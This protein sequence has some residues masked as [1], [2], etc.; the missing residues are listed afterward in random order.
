M[1]PLWIILS[2]VGLIFLALKQ[3][4]FAKSLTLLK[5]VPVT[6]REH[7][8][9]VSLIIPACN[10]ATMIGSAL[11]S[12][13][14]MNY[15][16]LEIIAVNDRSTDDTGEILARLAAKS[17]KVKAITVSKLPEGWLGKVHA[18]HL[19]L[20]SAT[21][22]WILFTDADV[23][24]QKE[25]LK[26][27]LAHCL[28]KNIDFLTL[29]PQIHARSLGLK[30]CMTQFLM[31][32]SLGIDIPRMREAKFPDAVGC[33]AFNLVR[34]KAYGATRGLEWLKMEVV[35]DGSFA[36]MMKSSGASCDVLSGLGEIDLEWYP[37]VRGY[38][39]GLEKNAFSIFQYLP[40]AVV[41][42][43]LLVV[44]WLFGLVVAPVLYISW[45]THIVLL[46]AFVFYQ[47][48][49]YKVLKKISEFPPY[50]LLF[51]PMSLLLSI[52]VIWRSMVLFLVR[53]G[54]YWRKTFYSQ[55][56]LI[57]NQRLKLIDLFFF[58]KKRE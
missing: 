29:V 50:V 27:A 41:L 7:W 55:E 8:P 37:N 26:K 32:G 42:F 54:I 34:A 46:A 57:L 53:G 5:D 22:E 6:E 51:L 25:S 52:F 35:D 14:Q 45:T 23:H 10:E 9:K 56:Q 36:L 15:P 48:S 1:L 28:D 47:L 2:A 24:Y 38:V 20:E 44:I 16:N 30:A 13:L 17:E 58:K 49:N 3:L 21:G 39:L 40:Q 43:T 33:G 18:Q 19:A 11:E 4:S 12:L 31:A